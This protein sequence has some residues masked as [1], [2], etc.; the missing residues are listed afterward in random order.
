MAHRWKRTGVNMAYTDDLLERTLEELER[1]STAPS[2]RALLEDEEFA[3][4]NLNASDRL[5]Q[6]R[7]PGSYRGVPSH[8]HA[9]TSS[10]LYKPVPPIPV[11]DHMSL[12]S[13]GRIYRHPGSVI[14]ATP[15]PPPAPSQ[16]DYDARSDTSSIYEP[17]RPR[18]PS[19]QS[20]YSGSHGLPGMLGYGFGGY[21][22]SSASSQY[23]SQSTLRGSAFSDYFEEDCGSVAEE[24]FAIGSCV[25]CQHEVL[26]D[27]SGCSA[28]DKVY[29]ISCFKCHVCKRELQG[30]AFFAVQGQPY[31]EEDY[32]DTL[33]KC[34]A[35]QKPILERILRATGRPFHPAC[36]SCLV[37][38]RGLDGV[39]FTV[40]A[41][42]NIYCIPDFH[43]KFAP[44]CCVCKEP[45]MPQGKGE[46]V[47][48]VAL[49]RSFH[50]ACYRCEDCGLLL[51]QD[52]P[53]YPLDGHVLCRDCNAN[54][55]QALTANP[56]GPSTTSISSVST[57]A[58]GSR[59]RPSSHQHYQ[60]PQQKSSQNQQPQQRSTPHQQPQ[61]RSPQH[62][63]PQQRS[64]QHQQPQQRSPQHQ[65]PRQRSPQHQQPQQQQLKQQAQ[66]QQQQDGLTTE[67]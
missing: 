31:C 59:G 42:N 13:N 44:R 9:T 38:G 19:Q 21:S 16:P 20:T 4:R 17:L 45:I 66:V 49:D 3:N 47:R 14:R 27:G 62:Q 41:A 6:G 54:R 65:Q 12:Y 18:A 1:L 64:P 39:P 52:H 67:L 57:T 37:C 46:T 28:M 61:Q 55:V 50:V 60:Q 5:V 34:T 22:G 63:Q 11:E 23:S 51:G 56:T 15:P 58:A 35:C 26:N 32:L 8:P 25:E 48:I 10:H 2:P 36:F 40:D 29:H 30:K 53:C 7:S 24:P 43:K 33:E